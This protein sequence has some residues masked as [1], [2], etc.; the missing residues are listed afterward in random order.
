MLYG[1]DKVIIIAG[2]NKIVRDLDEAIK[3]TYMYQHQL[4]LKDY[5]EK[6]LAQS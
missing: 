4:I 1:P 3:E 6:L 2:V 5:K